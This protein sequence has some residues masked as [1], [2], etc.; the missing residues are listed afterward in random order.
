MFCDKCGSIL[1]PGPDGFVCI[2]CGAKGSDVELGEEAGSGKE[3]H[4]VRDEG[5]ETL[6]KTEVECPKCDNNEAYFYV[7]QTR[8]ADESPTAFYT[9]TKCGHKWRDYD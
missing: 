1:V 6:P 8:S 9:C 3:V 4:M 2:K 5:D 7:K